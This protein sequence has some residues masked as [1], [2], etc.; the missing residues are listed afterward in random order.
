M[1]VLTPKGAVLDLPRSATVLD[2][3]Y[4]IHSDV[5]HHCR[6]ARV[7]GR[8]VPLTQ[9]LESGQ[10]VE[11]L[12]SR[13]GEPS[14]DWLNPLAGFLATSRARDKVRAFFRG[15]DRGLNTRYGRETLERE[16][17]RLGLRDFRH[18][19]LLSHFHFTALDDLFAAV[20]A[21]DVTA[22]QVAG[23][24]QHELALETP[25][26]TVTP[27]LAAT[28]QARKPFVPAV[29][30]AG[31]DNLLTSLARCCHPLPGE[32]LCGYVTR[33]HGITVH[34]VECASLKRL[35]AR[36]PERAM[37]AAWQG[38]A[39]TYPVRLTIEA[40]ERRDL[41]SDLTAVIANEKIRVLALQTRLVESGSLAR[42][43][44]TLAIAD[45]AQLSRLLARLSRVP[46]VLRA[47]RDQGS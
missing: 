11:I 29:T 46:G 21:G 37:A 15:Q 44:M 42:L 7:D 40:Q 33:G 31:V 10:Q 14:R 8:L 22:A 6:G 20:G 3:A 36:N 1:Y 38:R 16:L 41:L 34:R 30:V 47:V 18:E 9:R 23:A 24:V 2:F 19:R 39:Q 45:L 26:I 12:T 4:Y 43:H 35:L 17:E 5:G 32:A 25:V 13:E 27:P 28:R